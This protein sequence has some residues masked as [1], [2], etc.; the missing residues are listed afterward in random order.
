MAEIIHVPSTRQGRGGWPQRDVI[1]KRLAVVLVVG[2]LFL[3]AAVVVEAS[4]REFFAGLAG[5]ADS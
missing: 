2:A 3:Q 5:M 4:P 1:W